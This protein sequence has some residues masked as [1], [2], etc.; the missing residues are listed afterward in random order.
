VSDGNRLR[1]VLGR[2]HRLLSRLADGPADKPTLVQDLPVA[3][4]T[5]DRGIRDLEE[6]DCVERVD[7]EFRASAAGRGALDAFEGYADATDGVA[8]AAC[9]LAYLPAGVTLPPRVLA[10]A[11]VQVAEDHA[12]ERVIAPVG[13]A[14]RTADRVRG[15]APVLYSRYLD[16][17][18]ASVTDGVEFEAVVGRRVAE[19]ANEIDPER[20][21]RIRESDHYESYVTD[22]EMPYALMLTETD[23]EW[24]LFVVVYDAGAPRGVVVNE[25]DAAVAWGQE[26]FRAIRDAAEPLAA[27]GIGAEQTVRESGE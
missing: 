15:T 3:R 19:S 11:D 16:T 5:V 2:R 27:T 24:T 22:A 10:D 17:L 8:E 18:H 9:L 12:P 21:G 20:A 14:A 26:R 13:R 6:V 4:S 25:S 1:E 23:G 7:G